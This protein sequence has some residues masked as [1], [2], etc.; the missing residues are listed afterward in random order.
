MSLELLGRTRRLAFRDPF[1]IARSH[2][3]QGA[4]TVLGELRSSRRPDLVGLGEGYPDAF[5]GETP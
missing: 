3:E 4:T 5:Y 2:A 1:R